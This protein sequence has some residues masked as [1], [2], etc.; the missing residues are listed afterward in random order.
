MKPW[1]AVLKGILLGHQNIPTLV[2]YIESMKTY[3]GQSQHLDANMVYMAM[4]LGGLLLRVLRRIVGG[5]PLMAHRSIPIKSYLS[6]EGA[7]LNVK[8]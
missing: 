4:V 2:D 1:R 8:Y 7:C 6:R 3:M 5:L